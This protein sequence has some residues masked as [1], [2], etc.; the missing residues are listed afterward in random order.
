[1]MD[2]DL[3]QGLMLLPDEEEVVDFLEILYCRAVPILAVLCAEGPLEPNRIQAF[4][5]RMKGMFPEGKVVEEIEN[6]IIEAGRFPQELL[7]YL[8][9]Y[10]FRT[11]Q[12]FLDDVN[13]LTMS[14]MVVSLAGELSEEGW[15]VLLQ[16]GSRFFLTKNKILQEDSRQTAT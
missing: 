4:E 15:Q 1:M 7:P 8:V 3:P 5:K 10:L 16:Y 12:P 6:A 2:D 11:T 13:A 9:N 14:R